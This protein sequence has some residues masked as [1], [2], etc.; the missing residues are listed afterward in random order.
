M[1]ETLNGPE[2]RMIP[3][4]HMLKM[5]RY[6]WV[7]LYLITSL[8]CGS[9]WCYDNPAT[10]QNSIMRVFDI[11]VA[12]YSLLYSV[13]SLPNIIIPF[14]GGKLIDKWGKGTCL[15]I[16]LLVVFLGQTLQSFGAD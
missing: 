6:R 15:I 3:F 7:A 2:E 9:Y 5:V 8:V 14:F 12:R 10:L 1:Q 16:C 13:Y 11:G 4:Q